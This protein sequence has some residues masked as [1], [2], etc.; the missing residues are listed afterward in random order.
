MI[1]FDP[2]TTKLWPIA[3][4]ASSEEWNEKETKKSEKM[5]N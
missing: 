5:K 2:K 1:Q 4:P 3:N